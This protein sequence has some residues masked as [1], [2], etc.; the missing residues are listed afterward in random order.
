MKFFNILLAGLY[1]I[2][3]H[4]T[5]L[6]QTETFGENI[7]INGDFSLAETAWDYQLQTI[8]SETASA[9]VSFEEVLK[10]TI[11][12]VGPYHHTIQALQLLNDEQ[13]A[14]LGAGGTWELRFDAMSPD[15][16][17]G[18]YI[19][20]GEVDGEWVNY[21][22]E[23]GWITIDENLRTYTLRANVDQIWDTMKLS[24]EVATDVKDVLIDNV[25]LRLVN[26]PA[27]TPPPLVQ[28]LSGGHFI[29]VDELTYAV[30]QFGGNALP[31]IITLNGNS[32][33]VCG[34][35]MPFFM[36]EY[37]NSL[38]GPI[39]NHIYYVGDSGFIGRVE[40]SSDCNEN[41][42]EFGAEIVQSPTTKDIL[43]IA[44]FQ[45]NMVIVTKD[46]EIFS[47]ADLGSTW[48]NRHNGDAITPNRIKVEGG[49]FYVLTKDGLL[50]QSEDLISYEE[51]NVGVQN[52]LNDIHIQS[53]K[54]FIA[55]DD[56][57]F[58]YSTDEGVTWT[59]YQWTQQLVD[60][61]VVTFLDDQIGYLA[62][63][64]GYI[65]KT[66][67]GGV[68]W[69]RFFVDD[70]NDTFTQ[71]N[72][73]DTYSFNYSS[74]NG[75]SSR[76]NSYVFRLE[77]L[78]NEA[79]RLA[80]RSLADYSAV[81]LINTAD[82]LTMSW[83]NFGSRDLGTEPRM[84]F[85]ND[86][87]WP[88]MYNFRYPW[89]QA[90]QTIRKANQVRNDMHALSGYNKNLYSTLDLMDF[91]L[92]LAVA[93]AIAY[94]QLGLRY[95][96]AF[97]LNESQQKSLSHAKQT[98][99]ASQFYVNNIELSDK[100]EFSNHPELLYFRIEDVNDFKFKS[101]DLSNS[102]VGYE[103]VMLASSQK[104]LEAYN[105]F[106][107]IRNFYPSYVAENLMQNTWDFEVFEDFTHTAL[108]MNELYQDRGNHDID[109][110]YVLTHTE[111]G[112]QYDVSY[113]TTGHNINVY[114]NGSDGWQHYA[115]VYSIYPGWGR[116]DQ[117][118]LNTIDGNYPANYPEDGTTN[119]G[120][121]TTSDNRFATYFQFLDSQNF[122]PERGLYFYSN[123]RYSRFDYLINDDPFEGHFPFVNQFE[124][125]LIRAEALVNTG[126]LAGAVTLLNDIR[127]SMGTGLPNLDSNA[128]VDE[129]KDAIYYEWVVEVGPY[130]L[131]PTA[132]YTNRRWNKLQDG[133]IRQLPVP[134]TVLLENNLDV[135]TY[136]GDAQVNDVLNI[137][138]PEENEV[139]TL[140][141]FIEWE[142]VEGAAYY[143]LE[144]FSNDN[145]VYVRNDL[146][147]HYHRV[148]EPL[149]K[150][151]NYQAIV[152]A[153]DSNDEV[154]SSS[155]WR[156]FRTTSEILLAPT[157]I[158]PSDSIMAP[159]SGVRFYWKDNC[160]ADDPYCYNT[161]GY[162]DNTLQISRDITFTDLVLDTLIQ[163][164]SYSIR[165]NKSA[166]ISTLDANTTYYWRMNSITTA[167]TSEWS[168]ARLFT[169]TDNPSVDNMT[170]LMDGAYGK[171][172]QILSSIVEIDQIY[173]GAEIY[174]FQAEIDLGEQSQIIAVN[175]FDA[176]SELTWN[177]VN[178]GKIIVASASSAEI[179]AE[180]PL[181][182]ILYQFNESGEF[183]G[184][185]SH[186][187][188][189]SEAVRGVRSGK[190][191]IEEFIA[192]DVDNNKEMDAYDA[193]VILHRTVGKKLITDDFV[194]S[195]ETDSLWNEWRFNAGD[196][197][198]DLSITA[199]DASL[200]L[201]KIVG[202]ID[203][204]PANSE[205]PSNNGVQLSV[206]NGRLLISSEDVIHSMT[207]KV[208]QNE[209][210]SLLK[211]TYLVNNLTSVENFED[212][213]YRISIA[214]P[215]GMSKTIIEIPYEKYI[216]DPVTIHLEVITDND[217][218]S[219]SY[220]VFEN[221]VSNDLEATLPL[222]LELFQNYP[223]PFNPT[224]QVSYA[225]PEA[226]HVT[227][228][229]FNSLG[230]RVMELVNGQQ[231]AGYHVA[232][233][234]AAGMSSGVY[235]YKLTTPSFSQTK[236]MLLIK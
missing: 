177:Y 56:G 47:S 133:T 59:Q 55:G 172:N 229:V 197:N 180:V 23:S 51:I 34:N 88:Y 152:V 42:R 155:Y 205:I 48:V 230:Q 134:S 52:T 143:V 174:S 198:K 50:I 157:L 153:Y 32:E 14:S 63:E 85:P 161:T 119:I 127:A 78:V 120:E 187:K 116:V 94:S 144:I 137:I 68:N 156:R 75:Q 184:E 214:S 211:P 5:A 99:L 65:F 136:G 2:Q 45:N 150:A 108:A 216:T 61:N 58:L 168:S 146:L 123:Y 13:R 135:Y 228:E 182:E 105:V 11:E 30:D 111:Q 233:F 31:P 147:E 25:Q 60:F 29:Q 100:D 221:G 132:W 76:I 62:G 39:N 234:D 4:N 33:Y 84:Q 165:F 19:F 49:N 220:Q 185:I 170:I 224:T 64:Y 70:V 71:I 154:I 107:E 171:T 18:I 223:N 193:A 213:Q 226:T 129:I 231:S 77:D 190:I 79:Q 113:P 21:L 43:D 6:A 181:F 192:G 110:D 46:G 207:L 7:I 20:L 106:K 219:Y 122:R 22:G 103:D 37:T 73:I 112:L 225:L 69:D 12:T 208:D 97:V 151:T 191:I 145:Q 41:L 121:L 141:P 101:A 166:M 117:K 66:T 28:N 16:E 89:D 35:S 109:W 87:S 139:V 15:G 8:G 67:D 93:E 162:A 114:S 175:N 204:F 27:Q 202:F 124:T 188:L 131:G 102:L 81:S 183:R 169:T 163:N 10:F 44:Y 40:V 38:Y 164:P 57:A 199:L 128:T 160:N 140:N 96:Q 82:W 200:I 178:E 179:S 148:F 138:S 126:D 176:N 53:S 232:T 149:E 83:G 74:H 159:T 227:I 125:A 54:S 235:L 186:A 118:V 72:P 203:V 218:N 90:Y 195:W 95:D 130:S 236:K 217:V 26:N 86:P 9:V 24:F 210:L 17:K 189:N 194:L 222:N 80:W 115:M 167:G 212:D 158:S 91:E 98:I 92:K 3:I 209:H 201:Q 196:V 142:S 104:F 206:D 1:L 36:N 173:E 215:T